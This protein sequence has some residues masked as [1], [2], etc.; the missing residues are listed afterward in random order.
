MSLECTKAHGQQ[1]DQDRMKRD[2][3]VAEAVLETLFERKSGITIGRG[4]QAGYSQYL[5]GYGVLLHLPPSNSYFV[6]SGDTQLF[7]A[8]RPHKEAKSSDV[9]N[10]PKRVIED[11]NKTMA[12]STFPSVN[13]SI[14][15]QRSEKIKERITVFLLDYGDL[16]GQLGEED[17]IL[18]VEDRSPFDWNFVMPSRVSSETI[19]KKG[20]FSAE[21]K[22]GDLN[23]YKNGKIS[24]E[25]AASRIRFVDKFM[26]SNMEQDLELLANI[27]DRLYRPD[28]SKTFYYNGYASYD[29]IPNLGVIYYLNMFTTQD[30]NLYMFV[31]PFDGTETEKKEDETKSDDLDAQYPEFLEELKDNILTY[32]RTVQSLAPE[33]MM[34]FHVKMTNCTDC[35]IPKMLKISIKTSDLRA[36]DQGKISRKT[37][38]ERFQVEEG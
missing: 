34:I 13:D 3:K 11:K 9:Y 36:F 32:G 27:F 7:G 29:R 26:E 19:D 15:Q 8:N 10:I 18:V 17:K 6:I 33:E 1:I 25:E 23:A 12:Y 37:A 16:I 30:K 24:R 2:I 21:I 14:N 31:F 20:R 35:N 22:K 5:P 28:L 38:K 4:E